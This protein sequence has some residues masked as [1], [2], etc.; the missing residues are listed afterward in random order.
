MFVD[1]CWKE[2]D[3][4]KTDLLAEDDETQRQPA[5]LTCDEGNLIYLMSDCAACGLVWSDLKPGILKKDVKNLK[6]RILQAKI[7]IF[8]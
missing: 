6:V 3:G 2:S 8:K 5:A 7:A 4:Y 1:L